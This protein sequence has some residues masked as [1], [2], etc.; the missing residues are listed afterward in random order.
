MGLSEKG[1]GLQVASAEWVDLLKLRSSQHLFISLQDRWVLLNTFFAVVILLTGVNFEIDRIRKGYI[2]IMILIAIVMAVIG[3][4]FVEV[5]PITGVIYIQPWRYFMLISAIASIYVG[6]ILKNLF[7]FGKYSG[8]LLGIFVLIVALFR[9]FNGANLHNL[10]KFFIAVLSLWGLYFVLVKLYKS[11]SVYITLLSISFIL[12]ICF[13]CIRGNEIGIK[14]ASAREWID[15]QLW[16]KNNTPCN[17]VFIVPPNTEGFRVESERTIYVDWKSGTL[18]NFDENYGRNWFSRMQ[19]LGFKSQDS[20]Q[21]DFTL[22]P[23]TVFVDIA[24][25]IPAEVYLVDYKKEPPRNFPIVYQND[26]FVVYKVK[27]S[28]FH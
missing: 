24:T 6:V 13:F 23:D 27:G 12:L 5:I 14:N 15:V 9:C 20:I 22:L 4:F 1:S 28:E 10:L 19:K 2:F 11:A 16:A 3:T 21:K 8:F 26:S 25:H 18:L 17:S 7:K